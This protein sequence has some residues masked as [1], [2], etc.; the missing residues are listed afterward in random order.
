M[1]LF[2]FY[3]HGAQLLNELESKQAFSGE[4]NWPTCQTFNF[5]GKRS[6]QRQKPAVER[7]DA[8][9]A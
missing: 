4:V 3:S 2:V 8:F 1:T 6:E 5:L 9:T 7:S